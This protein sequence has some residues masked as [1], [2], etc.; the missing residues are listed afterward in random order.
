MNNTRKDATE[1]LF[2]QRKNVY[3]TPFRDR[4]QE[5]FSFCEEYKQFLDCSK[6]E[7]LSVK[8]ALNI[9]V[10]AGFVPL[11]QKKELR[12]GDRV[13][14]VNR[15]KGILLAVIGRKS[16]NKGI[17]LVAAHIDAPR[18][19]LKPN[20]L[21]EDLSLALLK[22]HYY[23]GIKKYQW[24][25]IPL[26]LYGV[27]YL[28]DGSRV[29][30]SIGDKPEDPVFYI[31]DLLP[32]LAAEQMGKKL[33]QG[34]TGESLNLL[35]GSIP[36]KDQEAKER[37]KR[38]V[39]NILHE[40]YGICETDFI[41]AELEAVPAYGARDVGLDRS[42]IGAYGHDDRVCSYTALRAVCDCGTPDHTAVCMLVDKEE[43]GSMGNT[44]MQSRHFEHVL[45]ELCER[46][47]A[48]LRLCLTNSICLSADVG[49]ANDPTYPSVQE[50][51][52][53]AV[54]NGGIMLCKYTG[55]R[56]K[57]GSS[58]ASAELVSRIR[59]LFDQNEIVWQ[60]AELGKVDE[61]GGGTVA[62]YVANLDIDT[63]DC[64]VPLLS[65]HAPYE[66]AAKADVYMAYLA[67]LAF[68]KDKA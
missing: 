16:M 6:T 1:A 64:G 33:A 27:V 35:A 52:N 58:D 49:A 46:T 30:I 63:L 8:S 53:A 10:C 12:P 36:W 57:S 32:H 43:I 37:V 44:G 62:Q 54:L 2:Y 39:L 34:V 20:P 59:R 61:G 40:A 45:A 11:E 24:P 41:S 68:L 60:I 29:D 13:Y 31:T 28:A 19:D 38:N 14:T 67:Y 48:S 7:R 9:A 22:T 4:Q 21:Y 66:I 55:S 5:M 56:G 17:H 65:M 18:L 23:G 3:D 25:T 15:G 42:M 47:G 51:N 50:K 26:A